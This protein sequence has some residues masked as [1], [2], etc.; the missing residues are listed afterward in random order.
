M[1][2]GKPSRPAPAEKPVSLRPLRFEEAVEGLLAVPPKPK[3]G[4]GAKKAAPETNSPEEKLGEP[5]NQ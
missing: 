1:Q 4:S 2:D 5:G 3:K